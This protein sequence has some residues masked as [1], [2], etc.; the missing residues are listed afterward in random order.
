MTLEMVYL[1]LVVQPFL[2]LTT[3]IPPHMLHDSTH[4]LF[5]QFSSVLLL[6]LL[7]KSLYNNLVVYWARVGLKA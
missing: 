2:I 1:V 4:S 7:C 3:Y 5:H 6:L